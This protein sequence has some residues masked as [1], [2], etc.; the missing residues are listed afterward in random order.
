MMSAKQPPPRTEEEI[1]AWLV[2][3][4]TS[5]LNMAPQEIRLE[6]L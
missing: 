3:N 2:Q 1:R 4:I 5:R 6:T